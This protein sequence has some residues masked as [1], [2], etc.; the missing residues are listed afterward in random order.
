MRACCLLS[1]QSHTVTQSHSH[2]L[3]SSSFGHLTSRASATIKEPL[4]RV[5]SIPE[6][7]ALLTA[8]G[9][10]MMASGD[11]VNGVIRIFFHAKEVRF[12]FCG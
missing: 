9:V 3:S 4:H 5:P 1:E 11:P 8:R 2:F 6:I 7:E 10:C 12:L